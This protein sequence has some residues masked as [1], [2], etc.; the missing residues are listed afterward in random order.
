MMKELILRHSNEGDIVFDPFMGSGTTGLACR[1][2]NRKF[3]GV[4]LDENY[5]QISCDRIKGIIG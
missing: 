2:L 5:Y 4:E 3:V 1:D